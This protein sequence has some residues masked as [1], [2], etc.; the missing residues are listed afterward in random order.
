MNG[1]AVLFWYSLIF[2]YIYESN[3]LYKLESWNDGY[4]QNNIFCLVLLSILPIVY[5]SV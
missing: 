5:I 4:Y 2:Y 1:Y 3:K